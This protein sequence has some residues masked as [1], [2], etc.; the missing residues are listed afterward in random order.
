MG[1][2]CFCVR[3]CIMIVLLCA[4]FVLALLPLAFSTT[5]RAAIVHGEF[6]ADHS[7]AIDL[8]ADPSLTELTDGNSY[9]LTDD[10]SRDLTIA[11]GASVRLCLNGHVIKGSGTTAVIAFD[12]SSGAELYLYDCHPQTENNVTYSVNGKTNTVTIMG[13]AI[14]GGSYS[15]GGGIQVAGNTLF[16][17]GGTIAGNSATGAGANSYG[18]GVNLGNGYMYMYGGVI[19]DNYS[20]GFGGGVSVGGG[21][22]S[23]FHLY[24]GTIEGNTAGR[25]GGGIYVGDNSST[26]QIGGSAADIGVIRVGDNAVGI[27]ENNV[28]QNPQ[29]AIYVGGKIVSGSKIGITLDSSVTA[30]GNGFGTHNV[31]VNPNDIFDLD[32]VNGYVCKDNGAGG[33]TF[34]VAPVINI[35]AK[36][37]WQIIHAG[38]GAAY[39]ESGPVYE[40]TADGEVEYS[41]T[42]QAGANEIAARNSVTYYTGA[43]IEIG[44]VLSDVIPDEFTA[45]YS[46]AGG[47]ASNVFAFAGKH[48]TTLKLT[49]NG[50][51]E[52]TC[53]YASDSER[54]IKVAVAADKKSVVIEKTWFIISNRSDDTNAFLFDRTTGVSSYG[55]VQSFAFGVNQAQFPVYRP[56]LKYGDGSANVRYTLS[57]V[58]E[59]KTEIAGALNFTNDD[60]DEYINNSMPAGIYTLVVKVDE[61]TVDIG[62]RLWWSNTATT[63]EIVSPAYQRTY[64]FTVTP[65]QIKF[66]LEK[67]SEYGYTHYDWWLADGAD[68]TQMFAEFEKLVAD[69]APS[70]LAVERKGH[71]AN[72]IWDKYYYSDAFDNYEI[73][74][75]FARLYNNRYYAPSQLANS[76][77]GGA[78]GTYRVYFRISAPAHADF[79]TG[80][81]RYECFFTVNVFQKVGLPRIENPKYTGA[82]VTPLVSSDTR[83]TVE[84]DKNDDYVSGGKHYFMLKL[85]DP[86]HYRWDDNITTVDPEKLYAKVEFDIIA[87][88][89]TWLRTPNIVGWEYGSY[90]KDRNYIVAIPTYGTA[91]SVVM[92][93]EKEVDG[94]RE[95]V[96]GLNNF[97]VDENGYVD[98]D[99]EAKISAL[100]SGTYWLTAEVPATNDYSALVKQSASF[101]VTKTKNHWT[102]PISV[103]AW[104]DGDY[105]P[106][107]NV[108]TAE[109]YA[110]EPV[111]V[112]VDVKSGKQYYNSATGL[113]RLKDAPVGSYRLTATV[114]GNDSY[115]A[116]N[117]S[118]EFSVFEAAGGI[119]WWVILIIVLCV[120]FVVFLVLFIL[121]KKGIVQLMTEKMVVAMRTRADTDA[122]IAAVR[123]GKIA[124]E[125]A[126]AAEAAAANYVEEPDPVSDAEEAQPEEE[127]ES[128]EEKAYEP[129]END[130]EVPSSGDFSKAFKVNSNEQV[131]YGKTVLSKLITSPDIVKTRYSEIKN[132]LLAYKKARANMSR[133]RESYYI[134]RKCYARIAMRGKTLCL[135]LAL[136]PSDYV[137]KYNVEDMLSVKQYADTPCLL[138]I[139]SDRAVR[140]AKALIDE[141]AALI[142]AT[143]IERKPEN[144]A[145]LFKSIEQLEKKRLLSYNGRKQKSAFNNN[146]KRGE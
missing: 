20:A 74:Y 8:N 102:K 4:L 33:L 53:G 91:E 131:A 103:V 141:L 138:R 97:T 2:K 118:V 22:G 142:G 47:G 36:L 100:G 26:L 15:W 104:A 95:A 68:K 52:F 85:S 134:G 79:G 60:F 82:R 3:N 34:V 38:S 40:Y 57:S 105:N 54:G 80:N 130:V 67:T 145:E 65:A 71:W 62:T 143:P 124:A 31:G 96:D 115:S 128:E 122:T 121:V 41:T 101:M 88:T 50:E 117:D 78:N 107:K 69:N 9:Y 5:V 29:G 1:R 120:L 77:G 51:Y 44:L 113:N 63:A 116:L 106:K 39:L 144:Y 136:N 12:D 132:Y 55:I 27:I 14:I 28:Q 32:N 43:N 83:F 19:K 49:A 90:S 72:S 81:D 129:D 140:R 127:E 92:S 66:G 75:N 99:I 13:G 84:W 109:S 42:P 137:E 21:S 94:K 73:S 30:F 89:N 123:A 112:I 98:S 70:F 133:A 37:E 17:Y 87:V 7:G 119:A 24:G 11:V 58:G 139:R 86:A 48:V 25:Q 59:D 46:T 76:I 56:R 23:R 125:A 126:R 45:S 64:S 111:V 135:Y 6:K 61:V 114:D 18:G 93:I 108:I 146:N 16:M 35:P 110:G 10:L